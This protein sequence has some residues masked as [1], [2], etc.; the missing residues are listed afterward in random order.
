M[1]DSHRSWPPRGWAAA[2]ARAEEERNRGSRIFVALASALLTCIVSIL[3]R[4]V[5]RHFEGGSGTGGGG[6]SHGSWLDDLRDNA[7]E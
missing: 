4:K 3:L 5:H 2:A 7:L 1:P 6:S